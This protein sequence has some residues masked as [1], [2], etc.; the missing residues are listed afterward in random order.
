MGRDA[1]RWLALLDVYDVLG[2]AGFGALEYGVSL[3]SVPAAWVLA[4]AVLLALSF[5]PLVRK[6]RR[7]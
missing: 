2:L 6:G 1:R 4:G 5:W 7:S 3:W